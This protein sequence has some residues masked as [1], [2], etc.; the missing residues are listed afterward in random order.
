M[1]LGTMGPARL[2]REQQPHPG[3]LRYGLFTVAPPRTIINTPDD[4]N[5]EAHA[6]GGGLLYD[7]YGCGE[8]HL[9]EVE[10]VG[11]PAKT[12]DANS[13]EV[14]VLPFVVYATLT[15]GPRG[16]SMAYMSSK[17]GQRLF[18]S[19]QHAVEA[20]L[21]TGG[22]V[23]A[24]PRIDDPAGPYGAPTDVGGGNTYSNIVDA[25]SALEGHAYETVPYGHHAVLHARSAVAAYAAESHLIE[26]AASFGGVWGVPG[27][28]IPDGF[29]QAEVPLMDPVLRTPL[30]TKW[31]FGGGYP[32]TGV[33]GAAPAAG[34]TYIWI[35]G[36][37][38]VW[39]SASW[40]P[41]DPFQV[42]DRSINEFRTIA[43]RPY[44][45]TFDC[46][47]AYALVDIPNPPVP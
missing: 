18:S 15:C 13:P 9:Y 35:T 22:G 30:G 19:E 28:T 2:P 29:G 46:F 16:Q 5:L 6:F 21:W 45:A 14:E 47:H 33:D 24:A 41:P 4:P 39:R 36:N 10:C 32:G 34:K 23:G 7:P 43:E 11:M 8:A 12:F 17:T 40:S 42:M 44:L 38:A 3:P 26:T 31:V 20:A 27:V 37:V 25:V 1:P